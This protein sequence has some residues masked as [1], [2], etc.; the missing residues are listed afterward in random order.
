MHFQGKAGS[1]SSL[2]G[3]HAQLPRDGERVSKQRQVEELGR[4][5]CSHQA[6]SHKTPL[7]VSAM[8]SLVN[9]T[10][11]ASLTY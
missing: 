10:L 4:A 11:I 8:A 5:M 2:P 3:N 6:V 9:G 7:P 1:D